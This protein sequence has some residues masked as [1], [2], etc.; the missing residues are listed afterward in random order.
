MS[1]KR[2]SMR[3]KRAD[4]REQVLAR[5]LNACQAQI[6]GLCTLHATDVHEI[7]TRGRGGSIYDPENCL[8]LCR[9][10]HT[11]I[12][13]NPFWA[14]EHGFIVPS[15]AGVAEILAAERAR[16]AFITGVIDGD[17]DAEDY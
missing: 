6:M 7:L 17:A 13:D 3:P 2:A 14:Q 8:S 4:V 1:K 11:Y 12:T 5:D 9:S 15:W 10:C 16:L